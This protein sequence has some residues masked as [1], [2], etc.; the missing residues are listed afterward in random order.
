[1][2]TIVCNNSIRTYKVKIILENKNR[3]PSEQ[4]VFIRN[5][6]FYL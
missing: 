5:V 4:D 3:D 1:M 2:E 6:S